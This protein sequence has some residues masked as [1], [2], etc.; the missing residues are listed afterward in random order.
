MIL[1][2]GASGDVGR[3]VVSQL[4]DTGV[5]VRGT[6]RN[7]ASAGLL[8]NVVRG[9]LSVPATLDRAVSLVWP[10]LTAEATSA[11]LDAVTKR[12][13]HVV[14]LSSE[15]AGDDLEQQTCT[16]AATLAA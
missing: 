3:H 5:S 7:P 12:A 2:T 8:G 16:I 6:A 9:D 4:P 10:F 15:G 11:F 1:V 13:S 14:Y